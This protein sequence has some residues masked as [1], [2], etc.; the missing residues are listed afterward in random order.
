MECGYTG[1]SSETTFCQAYLRFS[2]D[3][4]RTWSEAITVPEWHD[5]NEV[6]PVRAANGDI[7]ALCRTG[8]YKDFRKRT[9]F[10]HYAGLGFCKSKDNGKT[11]SEVKILYD[12]GRHHA[13]TVLMPN[14]DIV[15]SHVVRLGYPDTEDGYP[16]F[17]IE[18]IV[19]KDNGE[20]WDMDNRYVLA[21]WTGIN[22]T[23]SEPEKKLKTAGW[24]CAPHT[25]SSILLPSGSILTAFGTNYRAQEKGWE[26]FYGPRD[27]G[28]VKW[29]PNTK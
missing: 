28:L 6:C 16:R 7:V 2:S 22:K 21:S 25:T 26:P 20:S 23:S 9:D 15:V 18:A 17:G 10:D 29:N 5:I 19:S 24:Y 8:V 12:W 1:S 4:G 14:G 3:E 11:W 13:S 27:T